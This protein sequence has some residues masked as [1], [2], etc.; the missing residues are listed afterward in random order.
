MN[1]PPPHDPL[2]VFHSFYIYCDFSDGSFKNTQ[3]RLVV[4]DLIPLGLQDIHG[5][6]NLKVSVTFSKA[7]FDNQNIIFVLKLLGV[8]ISSEYLLSIPDVRQLTRNT[9]PKVITW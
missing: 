1:R 5:R 7:L 8:L 6:L 2:K 4:M 9:K 3:Y